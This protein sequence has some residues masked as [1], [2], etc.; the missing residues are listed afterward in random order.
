MNQDKLKANKLS[1][2]G[3]TTRK[4]LVSSQVP[5]RSLVIPI[6]LLG[7]FL[8][9][10]YWFYSGLNQ[11]QD[12]LNSMNSRLISVEESFQTQSN[13]ADEKV[14]SILQD[15]K[16]LNSEVRKLWDLSNKKN[17]KNISLL[18]NK[19]NEIT[20]ATNSAAED[21]LQI[22]ASLE[23]LN[24]SMFDLEGRI[25]KLSALELNSSSYEKKFDD[26]AEAIDAIDAY[27]L[28]INQRLLA[29]DERLNESNLNP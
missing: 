2:R 27:R 10:F 14:G 22:N 24:K 7:L 20:E 16:L 6:I 25:A 26:L 21:Y 12:N 11:Q 3:L 28:Q 5:P 4:F 15:I 29:I 17:K 9:F 1:D 8:F 18:E 13:N 19:V 23:S